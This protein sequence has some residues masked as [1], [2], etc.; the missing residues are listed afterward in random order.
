MKKMIEKIRHG[1]IKKLGGFKFGD[2][3]KNVT[4]VS[5][6]IELTR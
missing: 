6:S 5:A 3:D 1:I 2:L 4:K